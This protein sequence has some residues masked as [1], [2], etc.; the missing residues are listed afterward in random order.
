MKH[1]IPTILLSLIFSPLALAQFRQT[2]PLRPVRVVIW[3][4]QQP[5]QKPAYD[6]FL[7]NAIAKYLA[8]QNGFTV[9]SVKMDDKEQG[10]P[11]EVLD[12]C[13]VLIWWGHVR[14]REVKEE[15]AKR[16]LERIK[17][18]KMSLIALHSAHWSKP[19]ILA[20]NDRA[21]EDALKEIQPESR[22]QI[23]VD[24]VIPKPWVAVKRTDPLT[25]SS[26]LDGQTMTITLPA[27]VFPA[28]RADGKPSHVKTLIPGHPITKDIP[29]TFDIP[30]TEMYDEPFHVPKPDW[31][32]FEESWDKGE[33]FRSGCLWRI[34]QGMAFYF[35]PGH[36]TYP[37]YKQK[38]PLKILENACRYLAE[39][40]PDSPAIRR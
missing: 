29:A 6:D 21:T 12:N 26:K 40:L 17:S 33:R 18:G 27:C 8:D 5:Q 19:F 1:L 39:E 36:E 20:M 24:Y 23:K 13:D 3:D 11:E 37:V 35:R 31:V 2:G 28:W 34:G 16:I 14:H 10:L 9:K 22:S 32:I 15:L 7:G 38:L 25:P 30:Q 4:E